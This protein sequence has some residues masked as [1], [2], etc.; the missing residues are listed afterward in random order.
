[1][2]WSPPPHAASNVPSSSADGKSKSVLMIVSFA[3]SLLR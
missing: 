1:L 3:R 2:R